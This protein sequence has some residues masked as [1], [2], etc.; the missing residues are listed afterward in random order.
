MNF[1]G[2]DIG[3]TFIKYGVIDEN[4]NPLA[5]G[6]TDTPASSADLVRKTLGLLEEQQKAHDI[7]AAGIGIA[8]FLCQT[9][10][11]IK[12]SPNLPFLDGFP[13]ELRLKSRCHIPIFVGNDANL[14][15]FGVFSLLEDPKPDSFIHLTLGT[16]I[17][18]GIILNGEIWQGECGFGAE[19]GH[20]VVNPSGRR[21]GC[22]GTGCI[23]TEASATGIV[24]TYR[25]LS[26]SGS[27]RLSALEI[28][29][30]YLRKDKPALETF[31]RA[32][33]YLG[34]LLCS[35]IHFLNPAVISIGG[36]AADAGDA[37][38]KPAIEVLE[39]RLH[40]SALDCT[41]IMIA[42]QTRTGTIGAAVFAAK[43]YNP[44]GWPESQKG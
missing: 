25:E 14:S 13:F 18:S 16:G 43:S 11:I 21:C 22:G 31:Q 15:A 32:G 27:K 38:L 23:E 39:A 28:Y 42:P 44:D 40:Q 3:G 33:Y 10:K 5:A 19:L 37:L 9:D 36:G 26:G 7:R 6:Q 34:I 30:L 12:K 24:K 29:E 4:L 8:G 35:V 17:G 2:I 41:R 20:V 1:L